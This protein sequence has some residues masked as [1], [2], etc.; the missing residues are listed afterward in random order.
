LR[1]LGGAV[2]YERLLPRPRQFFGDAAFKLGLLLLFLVSPSLV[3]SVAKEQALVLLI[4]GAAGEDTYEPIF[5]KCEKLWREAA[6]RGGAEV[7]TVGLEAVAS[8]E[9]DEDRKKVQAFAARLKETN[10]LPA[11]IVMIGHGTDNGKEAK[12]NLRG[13]DFSAAELADWLK[14][15]QRPLI[16]VNTASASGAFI[17]PL[18]GANRIVVTATRSGGEQNFAHFGEFMAESIGSLEADLDKDE[19]TSLLESFLMASRRVAD[20]YKEEGRLATEHA[21]VEDNGDGMGTPADWFQGVRAVKKAQGQASV[22]GRR[23]Q[24]VHLISN[25]ADQK[26]SP[27]ARARRDE[28]EILIG[29]LRDQKTS[30][31]KDEYY[32][33]LEPLL[34]EIAQIYEASEKQ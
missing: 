16:I 4:V 24:Q 14:P 7:T 2:E 29:Q 19:Q 27:S 12:F 5:A 31:A 21:L 26:L 3:A 17:K 8:A 10:S 1:G 6:A 25:A 22:D 34:V 18:S 33:K 28:L 20:F 9:S 23:A 13:P 11:W 30:I 32:R 15:A